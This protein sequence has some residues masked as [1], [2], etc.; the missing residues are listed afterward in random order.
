MAIGRIRDFQAVQ[1]GKEEYGEAFAIL[2]ESLGMDLDT[3]TVLYELVK[4]LL[5]DELAEDETFMSGVIFGLMV[6]LIAADH[7]TETRSAS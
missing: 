5:G 1:G 7:A 2:R 6:G 4:D 3:I